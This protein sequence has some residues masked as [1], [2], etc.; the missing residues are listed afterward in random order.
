M[1]WHGLEDAEVGDEFVGQAL[2][3][4]LEFLG[5][6]FQALAAEDARELA[7]HFPEQRLPL[8]PVLQAQVAQVEEGQHLV[9]LRDGVVV[10]LGEVLHGDIV[11]GVG[12]LLEDLGLVAGEGDGVLGV[13]GV[14]E[15]DD[16]HHHHLVVG[17]DGPARFAE[18]IR[19]GHLLLGADVL[20]GVDHV[21]GVLRD[22]VVHRA[23]EGGLAAVVVHAEAAAHV[24]VADGHPHL[25]QLGVDARGLLH[26][27]LD[28]A[29]IRD[30][31]ADVEVQLDH[32]VQQIALLQ[33]LDGVQDFAG[34]EAE[35]GVI[36]GAGLPLAGAL[37]IELGAQ[38]DEGL[39]LE[40]LGHLEDQ[41]QLGHLLDGDD[42]LASGLAGQQ[43][44]AD[45]GFVLVAV[46][47]HQG[48]RVQIQAEGD[49]Q[50]GLGACL[51]A[52]VVLVAGTNDLLDHF[53][54]LVG[55][56]RVDALVAALI[57]ELDDGVPEGLVDLDHSVGQHLREPQIHRSPDALLLQVLDDLVDI[58]AQGFIL[59]GSDLEMAFGVDA[60]VAAPPLADSVQG[61]GILDR[62]VLH[63]HPRGLLKP[64]RP[65]LAGSLFIWG[66][67]QHFQ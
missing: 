19:H 11:A 26:G 64:G 57:A 53:L 47:E 1:V 49:H 17:H 16:V 39:D 36:P 6:V 28:L 66:K 51:H 13:R 34:R 55:L 61:R 3:E 33:H 24:E 45:E 25:P 50:F 22:G 44:H 35:F 54:R 20:G 65:P 59:G 56:H 7:T 43:G 15:S 63:G 46:A 29:D 23:A 31:A 21:G 12:Q 40:L 4:I 5:H 18:Q 48:L 37:G 2:V 30:L 14:D 27:R 41:R 9:L 42:H 10:H 52:V 67:V 38:A 62:P 8:A 32:A 58:A 60:E